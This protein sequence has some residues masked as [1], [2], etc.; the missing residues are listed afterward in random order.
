MMPV[1][2][3]NLCKSPSQQRVKRGVYGNP[4]QDVYRCQACGHFFL[5]PLLSDD[6]E[7]EF[8][9]NEY[10]AFLLKRG[11]VKNASPDDHFEKN[12]GEGVRRLNLVTEFLRADLHVLEVGS[13]SGFFLEQIR[14][15]TAGVCG[16][17]PNFSHREF[18][19]RRGLQT[20]QD[21]RDL[22]GRRFDLIFSY[23]VLEHVKEPVAFINALKSLLSGPD[24]RLVIEVPHADEA[25]VS[26]YHARGY[27]EFVWQRA[28]CSYF[29]LQSMRAL[30]DRVGMEVDCRPVQRYDISNHMHWVIEG[31]PGG[32]G[33]YRHLFSDRMDEEYRANLK[34]H[35]LCD[36]VLAVAKLR[37]PEVS[38]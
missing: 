3:C 2:Q 16:V 17:E 4:D 12:N 33:K 7:E 8:Y 38:P 1:P 29:T 30:F 10:P 21:L 31:K 5:S 36:T 6:D 9:I 23:Y 27:N 20:F 22:H 32:T 11:D 25:L 34:Q 35:W 18:A 28:H 14:Q 13:A 15:H 26:F 24:A 37:L 19:N